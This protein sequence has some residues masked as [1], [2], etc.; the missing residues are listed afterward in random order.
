MVASTPISKKRQKQE[1]TTKAISE[2]D[3]V[4]LKARNRAAAS[5]SRSSSS[6]VF[7]I[8]ESYESTNFFHEILFVLFF[9]K[10]EVFY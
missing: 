7:T 5:R 6:H 1:G 10:A 3:K 9:Y 2:S 8:P 4:D